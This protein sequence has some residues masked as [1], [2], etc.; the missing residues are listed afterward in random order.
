[1]ILLTLTNSNSYS[2]VIRAKVRD[3]SNNFDPRNFNPIFHELIRGRYTASLQC[4]EYDIFWLLF[5]IYF[6][7]SYVLLTNIHG[8][9]KSMFTYFS[10]CCDPSCG[11]SIDSAVQYSI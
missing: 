6:S 1:M 4:L 8:G 2:I 10:T 11:F 7:K 5:R 3:G 9:F